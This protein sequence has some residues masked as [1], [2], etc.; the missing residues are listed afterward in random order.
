MSDSGVPKA[1]L[2]SKATTLGLKPQCFASANQYIQMDLQDYLNSNLGQVLTDDICC[3]ILYQHQIEIDNAKKIENEYA[4]A[5]LAQ[6]DENNIVLEEKIEHITEELKTTKEKLQENTNIIT[7]YRKQRVNRNE[8]EKIDR[9]LRACLIR[10]FAILASNNFK[11][12]LKEINDTELMEKVNKTSTSSD[13]RG[14]F[15]T[16]NTWAKLVYAIYFKLIKVGDIQ[17]LM[18][19]KYIEYNMRVHPNID[20]FKNIVGKIETSIIS[21]KNIGIDVVDEENIRNMC[22]MMSYVLP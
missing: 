21:M 7:E 8:R 17:E 6:V 20:P 3:N 22:R 1:L 10:Y 5:A 19:K 15:F 12:K 2:E 11:D 9:N 18:A 16:K 14:N 4:D 13:I